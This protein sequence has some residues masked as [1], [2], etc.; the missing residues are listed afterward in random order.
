MFEIFRGLA[1]TFR[2]LFRRKVTTQ[3]PEV[4]RPTAPRFHGRHRLN[5]RP[6]GLERCVGCELCA[7]ACPADA[8]LVVGDQNTLEE[9]YSPGER[10]ARIYEIDY[11]RCIFCGY[12]IEACPVR[13]LTMSA[14]YEMA[15]ETREALVYAKDRLLVPLSDGAEPLP[16]RTL[17][18]ESAMELFGPAASTSQAGGRW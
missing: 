16:R 17:E 3:Y 13:A 1:V 18:G 9:R 15:T 8:I 5:R 11:N 14:E 4:K 2:H 12:C 10:Y 7:W 6:D